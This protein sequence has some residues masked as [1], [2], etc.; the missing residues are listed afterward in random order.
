M[1]VFFSKIKQRLIFAAHKSAA[2]VEN[3][4][5]RGGCCIHP[6]P[7]LPAWEMCFFDFDSTF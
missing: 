2:D 7:V 6:A 1:G 5:R 3:M 4:F